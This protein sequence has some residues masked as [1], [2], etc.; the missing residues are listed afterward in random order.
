MSDI[1]LPESIYAPTQGDSAI[2]QGE[3]L[4]GLMQFI[5]DVSD[6]L[7]LED[8]SF[9]SLLHPYAIVVSQDCDLDWDFKARTA[10]ERN[11]GKLI[12]NILFCEVVTAEDLRGSEGINSTLW[13]NIRT[14]KNERYQ[15]L[16]RILPEQE[17]LGLGLPELGVDFKRYFTIPTSEVYAQFRWENGA[18]RR[19]WFRSPYA[20]H[21]STRFHYYQAR[22]ALPSDHFSEPAS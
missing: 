12:P 9:S 14:N 16:Q 2:R 17:A 7:S 6:R 13:G 11:S 8:I 19:C 21:F 4:T 1:V 15:F 22:I 18:Q 5:L 10:N 20:E 3:I